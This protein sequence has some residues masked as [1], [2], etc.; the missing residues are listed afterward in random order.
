M[1][2]KLERTTV[3]S[4]LRGHS[5]EDQKLSFQ[6]QY[7]LMQSKVLQNAPMDEHSA[8]L[9]TCIKLPNGFQAFVLPIFEWPLKTGFNVYHK[10]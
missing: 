2:D 5:K 1:M 8:V 6:D 7:R 9:L 3:K 4:V 10:S